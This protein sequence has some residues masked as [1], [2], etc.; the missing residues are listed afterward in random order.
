M[1]GRLQMISAVALFSLLSCAWLDAQVPGPPLDSITIR[2]NDRVVNSAGETIEC[3]ILDPNPTLGKDLKVKIRTVTTILEAA[4]VKQIIPR[5]SQSEAYENWAKWLRKEGRPGGSL[6][7]ASKRAAAELALALWC[8]T[9]HV[10]LSGERPMPAMAHG[11]LVMSARA[12]ASFAA[13][14]PY[15]LA[16]YIKTNALDQAELAPLNEELELYLRAQEAGISSPDMDFR[17]GMILSRRLGLADGAIRFFERVLAAGEETSATNRS[18]RRQARELLA[19]VY[20][21]GGEPEK[22]LGLYEALLQ[23]ELTG[24]LNFEGLY[25]SAVILVRMGGAEKTELARD[26]FSEAQKLQPGF[27]DV[28]L[29]LAA[30]DYASGNSK[31]AGKRLKAYLG[32]VSDD[33]QAQVDLAIL[34]ITEGRFTKAERGLRNALEGTGEPSVSM[35]ARLGLGSIQELRGKLPEAEAHYRSAMTLA[36]RNPLPG[37]MLATILIRQDRTDEAAELVA[38]IRSAYVAS[39]AVFGACSRLQA[40]IDSSKGEVAKSS[41]N[42]EFAVDVSPEDPAVLEAAGLA[43]LRQGK[44]EQGLG[45]L[46]RANKLQ[47]GRPATLNGLGYYNYIQGHRTEASNFFDQALAALKKDFPGKKAAE[48][49][50][51]R[52]AKAYATHARE[53]LRDLEVLQVWVDEFESSAEGLIDGWTEI[54]LFGIDVSPAESNVVFKGRQQKTPEGE[55][56][57]RLLRV[58]RSRDLERVAVRMRIDSGDVAP[59]LNLTGPD[60]TRSALSALSIYRDFDGRVRVRMRSAKGDWVEPEEPA[61][62]GEGVVKGAVYTGN[63]T[64][65]AGAAFHTLEIRKSRTSKG[66]T[67]SG[68][69]DLYFD[70]EPVA[71]EVQVP[72]LSSSYQLSV[73]ARTE[74]LGN[75]YSVTVD[76]FKVYRAKA[77]KKK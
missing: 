73:M 2:P 26:R 41:A 1:M 11:H 74:A 24:D 4:V 66:V 48:S 13:V 19:A 64:W 38:S 75:E 31:E 5:R 15:L 36:E 33:L 20:M 32:K 7:G 21:Q 77:K 29:R 40:L 65:A 14:Y 18:Q 42:L 76:N 60:G 17:I 3:K 16:S 51:A 59:S 55:S 12:D 57:I 62:E 72:G 44:L 56:G 69:F 52:D 9:P 58:Y 10:K 43:F 47:Q 39:Q 23:P 27:L 71:R 45:Y 46:T 22:A 68:M 34:D 8:R 25:N 67:R 54:E 6:D 61:A 37:L 50:F 30:L 28:E 49:A 63:V 70:G 53:L 35:R